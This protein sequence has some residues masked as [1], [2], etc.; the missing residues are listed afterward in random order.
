MDRGAW[1]ATIHSVAESD[2]TEQG[3]FHRSIKLKKALL[4]TRQS[5]D[6][7]LGFSSNQLP[8]LGKQGITVGTRHLCPFLGD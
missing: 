6:P 5:S 4:V 1:R 2:R 3:N 7:P 8:L